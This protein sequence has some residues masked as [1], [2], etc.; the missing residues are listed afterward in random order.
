MNYEETISYLRSLPPF[1]PRQLAPGEELFNLDNIRI[2]LRRLGNPAKKLRFVH[3]AGSNGKGS[4]CAF[5]TQI[6]T[7]SGYAAGLFTSPA[8]MRPTE[9]IRIGTEEIS[10][11]DYARFFTIVRRESEEMQKAAEGSPSEF[12]M[13]TAAAFLY[14][15]ERKCDIIVLEAGLGGRL[16]STN[17][18]PSPLLAVFTPVSLEHTG[19]LGDTLEKIAKEKAGIIKPGCAVLL[20]KQ[21]EEARAVFEKAAYASDAPLYSAA[22][23]KQT[24]G[25]FSGQEITLTAPPVPAASAS[26]QFFSEISSY[27][28]STALHSD[29]AASFAAHEPASNGVSSAFD[30]DS[31]IERLYRELSGKPLRLR[32]AAPCQAD[33]AAA[34][35]SAAMLLSAMG[36]GRICADS[37]ADGLRNTSWPGR[38]EVIHENPFIIVDGSHN[39]A[40]ARTLA[41]GLKQLFPDKKITFIAGI[42][43]DKN[44]PDVFRELTPLAH[45]FMTVTPPSPRAFPAEDLA[46][47]LRENGCPADSFDTVD[48]AVS[49]ALKKSGADD[50]ICAFGSLYLVS[51]YKRAFHLCGRL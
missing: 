22:Q 10:R 34:A 13:L 19:M 2:L 32:L 21:E 3:V 25:T 48:A 37:I 8:V 47:Y 38:F 44:Y 23:V 11:E 30:M 49:A 1:I 33:N 5:L 41:E 12:E 15:Q 50:V 42:L 27:A 31:Q 14:F 45:C 26:E 7:E 24:A 29:F 28:A 40:G 36:Y 43:R 6:L 35:I 39:P 20:G 18:I 17:I 51:A 4:V 46:L 16:D 9:Q